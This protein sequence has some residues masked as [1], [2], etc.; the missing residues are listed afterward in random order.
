M[1][2]DHLLSLVASKSNCFRFCRQR[3][4]SFQ[5]ELSFTVGFGVAFK[6]IYRVTFGMTYIGIQNL[7]GNQYLQMD[8]RMIISLFSQDYLGTKNSDFVHC[9]FQNRLR[10]VEI[11][12]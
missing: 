11:G 3:R 10:H 12:A 6:I 7:V 1:F 2:P 9:M 4:L 5:T 8:N